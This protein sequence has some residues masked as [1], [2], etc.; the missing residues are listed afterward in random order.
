VLAAIAARRAGVPSLV[1][2]DSGEFVSHPDIDYG[3][4]RSWRGRRQVSLAARLATRITVCSEYMQALARRCGVETELA[5]F[6]TA[7]SITNPVGDRQSGPP[8]RLLQVA[9]LNRVKDQRTLLDA[10][11]RIVARVR[12]VHLDLVG[13]DAL[14]G[15]MQALA[16]RLGIAAH[17]TFHG[18]RPAD[19]IR[20]FIARAHLF[21][22]SSRHEGAGLAVL[23]AAADGLPTV[24]TRVGYVADWTPSASVGVPVGDATA[25]ADAVV[26]LLENPSERDRLAQAARAR[27]AA[28]HSDRTAARYAQIYRELAES[29][30]K[31]RQGSSHGDSSR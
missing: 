27:A 8:W 25:L 10:I 13:E 20:A 28:Y 19:E 26:S 24:G 3:L 29:R 12:D 21:V 14:G 11:T 30:A 23:E 18:F 5:P 31:L 17:V 6:G 7:F 1:T 4:Q 16:N 9:S 2:F 15:E 22:Q